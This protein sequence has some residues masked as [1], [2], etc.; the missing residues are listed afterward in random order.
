MADVIAAI[1]KQ[2][3]GKLLT[4]DLEWRN[5]TNEY[6]WQNNVKWERQRMVDAGI[7]RSDSPR[8]HWQLT[9]GHK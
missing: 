2:L 1:G 6:V 5:A 4:G 3:D 7:L 8:G 9:E